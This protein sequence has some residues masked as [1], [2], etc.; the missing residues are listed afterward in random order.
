LQR[1]KRDPGLLFAGG[2]SHGIAA[3]PDIFE[4]LR[5]KQ[6]LL[7]QIQVVNNSPHSTIYLLKEKIVKKIKKNPIRTTRQD[8]ISMKIPL[9]QEQTN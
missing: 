8:K 5:N 3:V 4:Y 2:T 7:E 9:I 1:R 6:N